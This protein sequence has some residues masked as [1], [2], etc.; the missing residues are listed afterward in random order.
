[1]LNNIG[2]QSLDGT[3]WFPYSKKKKNREKVWLIILISE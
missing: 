2:N 3:Y 1:M